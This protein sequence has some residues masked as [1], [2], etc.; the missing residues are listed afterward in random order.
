MAPSFVTIDTSDDLD[1]TSSHATNLNNAP[2]SGSSNKRTLLLAP[3]S[4]ASHPDAL[5]SVLASHP[6]STTD[7]QMLDRLSAGLVTLPES[8]Y[9]LILVL[10]DADGSR[11]E[12]TPLLLSDRNLFAK[13]TE[14]LRPGGNLQAQDGGSA[15]PI[16][17]DKAITREA[18]LAGLVAGASGFSKP[19][20]GDAGETVS[21][22]LRFGKNKK[23]DA[24]PPVAAGTVSL[25]GK[26]ET[27][28]LAPPVKSVPAGVGFVDLDDDFDDD[29]LIDEDTLLTEEDLKRPVN[30]RMFD[31]VPR[32]PEHPR[33]TECSPR[34]RAQGWQETP[35][36][37]GTSS[38]H[39]SQLVHH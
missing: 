35:C 26:S 14:A 1:F 38:S 20:Y 6:R 15:A 13:I 24:G 19:D 28:S 17:N 21:L 12:S 27:V 33:L 39:G 8:T 7:L 30:I 9:D 37:Q 4:V 34:V 36:V 3:P 16:V 11:K 25:G 22:G 10:S 32:Y 18:V 31:I 23:S 5:T 29:E 2:A